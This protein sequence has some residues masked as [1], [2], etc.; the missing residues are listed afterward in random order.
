MAM[1]KF[2]ENDIHNSRIVSKVS[3]AVGSVLL[4]AYL[5]VGWYGSSQ[6][7]NV[8][9][10]RVEYDQSVQLVDGDNYVMQGG[11]Y[12][13]DGLVGGIRTDG[14]T[15]GVFGPPS[16]LNN[17]AKTS[18]RSLQEL[19]GNPPKINE[20]L[21]LQGN[22]W[23]SNPKE[24]LGL[25]YSDVKY[26]GPLGDMGAWSI[27]AENSKTWVIGVHGIG[28]PKSEFLRF[29]KP[30][31]NIGHNVLAINYRNDAGNPASPDGYNHL[32][33]TEWQDLQ[34]AVH[35]AEQQGAE[36]VHLFG[37]SLGG[38]IIE[39]YLRRVPEKEARVG[40]V[41]LDSPVLDWNDFVNHR[42]KS[43]GYPGFLAYPGKT[44]A[45]LRAGV[46]LD[47][48]STRPDN[49]TNHRRLIFHSSDD[50]TVPSGPSQKLA[51]E[52]PDIVKY[53]N[54]KRGG[55]VRFWNYDQSRYERVLTDFLSN[56]S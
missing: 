4:A 51:E 43:Q 52:R 13:I 40:K 8:T 3:I 38:S 31:H 26:K 1:E 34:A 53:Q 37:L 47:R 19:Y 36:T 25:E 10:Q 56:K 54:S 21:S 49:I 48:I 33:D 50:R 45:Y 15:M 42:L 6:M 2:L 12:N 39:N 5:G 28:A 17:E 11:A 9:P 24:A 16:N 46:D 20:R 35:Y 44:V 14:S 18:A 22:I 27:P 55:H 41:V 7:L 32:G 23:T 29:I 30:L